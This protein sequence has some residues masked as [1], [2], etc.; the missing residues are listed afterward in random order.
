MIFIYKFLTEQRKI[1][2][3]QRICSIDF[4][5]HI[6]PCK[7]KFSL[8]NET[9]KEMKEEKENKTTEITKETNKR[10]TKLTHENLLL[11]LV[12]NRILIA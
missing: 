9:G 12:H 2:S 6:N 5:F 10:K 1:N 4:C 7:L 8:V 3:T 11:I